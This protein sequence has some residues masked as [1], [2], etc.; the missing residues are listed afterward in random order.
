MINFDNPLRIAI[1]SK[2]GGQRVTKKSSPEDWMRRLLIGLACIWLLVGV[3]LPLLDVVDRATH[4]ELV[5]KIE[6]PTEEEKKEDDFR[7]QIDIAGHAVLLM[8][9]DGK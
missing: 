7:G 9:E 2:A 5:V 4:I 8:L 6:E 3:V 1:N